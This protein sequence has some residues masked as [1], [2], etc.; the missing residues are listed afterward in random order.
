MNRERQTTPEQ[1]WMDLPPTQFFSEQ[2][3]AGRE[4]EVPQVTTLPPPSPPR[5]VVTRDQTPLEQVSHS[6]SPVHYQSRHVGDKSW[7]R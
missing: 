2:P 7:I 6:K 4:Q 3:K 1:E 5:R